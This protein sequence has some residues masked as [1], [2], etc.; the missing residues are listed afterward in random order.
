MRGAVEADSGGW[1][2]W[3]YGGAAGI[4]RALGVVRGEDIQWKESER[5]REHPQSDHMLDP[6]SP[7]STILNVAFFF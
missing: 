6:C 5:G 4:K 7:V 2:P 3:H 1:K